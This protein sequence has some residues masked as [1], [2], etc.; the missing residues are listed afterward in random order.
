M[1]SIAYIVGMI[2]GLA[3]LCG[4]GDYNVDV[5][6]RLSVD[7]YFYFRTDKKCPF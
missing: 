2:K 7:D 4:T 3:S 1:L 5:F 6:G